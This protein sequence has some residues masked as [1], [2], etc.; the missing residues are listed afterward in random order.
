MT[1]MDTGQLAEFITGLID[2]STAFR[3]AA[4]LIRIRGYDHF[5]DWAGPGSTGPLGAA[6]AIV[7]IARDDRHADAL[8]ARFAGWLYLTGAWYRDSPAGGVSG[9]VS[10]WEGCN[11]GRNRNADEVTAMLIACACAMDNLAEMMA[12]VQG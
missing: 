12:Q 2:A 4:D 7:T 11:P 3:R 6:G 8:L 5:A 1:Q 9:Q 10:S